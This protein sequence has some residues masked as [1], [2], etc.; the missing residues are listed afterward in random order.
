MDCKQGAAGT[1]SVMDC[2]IV[3]KRSLVFRKIIANAIFADEKKKCTKKK[4]K[5]SH[6]HLL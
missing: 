4:N 2:E 6:N 3:L 5:L 1:E